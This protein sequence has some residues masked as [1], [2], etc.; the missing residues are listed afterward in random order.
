MTKGKVLAFENSNF[1]NNL[2]WVE[3][4]VKTITR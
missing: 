1:A 2:S 4:P 3:I